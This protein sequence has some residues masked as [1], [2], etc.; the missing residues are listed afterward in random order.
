M[1]NDKRLVDI[2]LIDMD[3]MSYLVLDLFNGIID[4]IKAK[5]EV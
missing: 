2:E 3:L 4:E 5:Q 1:R